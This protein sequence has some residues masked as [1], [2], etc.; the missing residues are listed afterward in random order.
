MVS[1]QV[2]KCLIVMLG[3][4]ARFKKCTLERIT[5][6]GDGADD[7]RDLYAYP[8]NP[9]KIR[10]VSSD[11]VI[12]DECA[13]VEDA[14]IFEVILP[15]LQIGTTPFLGVSTLK[16]D[17]SLYSQMLDMKDD[18]GEP[19]FKSR[20]FRLAC[21]DCQEKGT[22][23]TCTHV[24]HKRPEWHSSSRIKR[25]AGLYKNRE[26]LLGQEVNIFHMNLFFY[27]HIQY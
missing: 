3:D 6:A 5:I 4:T 1:E 21:I 26:E 20:V 27:I 7:D 8:S 11:L 18:T 13:Y 14:L 9:D 22:P 12:V 19:I 23:E 16:D 2:K 10:G 24:E 25:L 17:E 15:L